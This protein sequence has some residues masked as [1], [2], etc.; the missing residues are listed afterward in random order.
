MKN[1]LSLFTLVQTHI[2][3]H[4]QHDSYNPIPA[5]ASGKVWYVIYKEKYIFG[6]G[7]SFWNWAPKTLKIS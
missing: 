5:D 1:K 2:Q 7:S 3:D 4:I 6:L